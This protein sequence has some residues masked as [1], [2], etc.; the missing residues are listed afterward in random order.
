MWFFIAC[1][2]IFVFDCEDGEI[3]S[4]R[5]FSLKDDTKINTIWEL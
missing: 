5:L 1:W 4:H 2:T 3:F